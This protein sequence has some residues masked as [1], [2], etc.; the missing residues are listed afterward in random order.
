MTKIIKID[1]LERDIVDLEQ[2]EDF[3]VSLR[4]TGLSK[5][6]VNINKYA[7][8]RIIVLDSK[9]QNVPV[10]FL[11]IFHRNPTAK[12]KGRKKSIEWEVS[13]EFE[14][15]PIIGDRWAKVVEIKNNTGTMQE[16]TMN[17]LII[18]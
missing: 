13:M 15:F 2:G 5:F 1:E 6:P 8:A 18:A 11:D 3:W 9:N 10:F 17:F 14:E 12:P 16:L 4:E 7:S